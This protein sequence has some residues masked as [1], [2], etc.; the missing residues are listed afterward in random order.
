MVVARDNFEW[1]ESAGGG[2]VHFAI[3]DVYTDGSSKGLFWLAR[4]GGWAVVA[5]DVTGRWL[6]TKRGTLGG[7]NVSSFRAELQALYEVLK[8]AVPPVRIH[9]DNQDVVDEVSRGRKWCTLAST[10]G[11]D[12]W[13]C[14]FDKLEEL[15][16]EGE[17]VVVK[18]KAH[19][20]WWD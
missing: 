8:I 13:R 12:L 6:W 1:A 16:D 2:S 15:R 17:V 7:L 11:A 18:V 3:G 20:G 14:I 4:R 5:L 9:I 19:I 10:A